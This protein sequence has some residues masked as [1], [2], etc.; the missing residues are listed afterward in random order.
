MS[1]SPKSPP[2]FNYLILRFDERGYGVISRQAVN[3]LLP[4]LRKRKSVQKNDEKKKKKV[5]KAQPDSV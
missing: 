4:Y 5:G 3:H 1:R 2:V